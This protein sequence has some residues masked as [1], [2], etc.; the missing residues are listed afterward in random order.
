[1]LSQENTIIPWIKATRIGEYKGTCSEYCGMQ[2]AWM[3]ILVIAQPENE[4]DKWIAEQQQ[5]PH[6]PSDSLGQA[7]MILYVEKSCSNCHS[8]YPEPGKI[9]PD[10][11]HVNERQTLISGMLTNTPENLSRW[12]ENPQKIKPGARMPNLL[13]D[14]GQV[15]ALVQ[16][17]EEM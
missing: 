5:F 4:Y 12:L 15:K 17:L 1:M 16:Y 11:T 8:I 3:R 2:H 14:H 6:V 7:G 10:L 13:L 9:G